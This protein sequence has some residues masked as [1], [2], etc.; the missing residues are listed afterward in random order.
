MATNRTLWSGEYLRLVVPQPATTVSG[1]PV[2]VGLVPGGIAGVCL[3]DPDDGD[4]ATVATIGGFSLFVNGV[5]DSVGQPI[6]YGDAADP[7]DR[8]SSD[9]TDRDFFGYALATGG[10]ELLPVLIGSSVLGVNQVQSVHVAD[11]SITAAKLDADAALRFATVT[12]T[13]PEIKLLNATPFELV[14]APGV[15]QM[16]EVQSVLLRQVV[17]AEVFDGGRT[18]DIGYDDV[19]TSALGANTVEPGDFHEVFT[20]MVYVAI[21]ED[22]LSGDPALFVNENLAITALAG[23]IGG[24]A[25]D[26]TVWNITVAYRVHDLS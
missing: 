16:L 19:T 13:A 18:L 10:N 2:F 5:V 1:S 20:D 23:E 25:T 6:Y 8:L 14:A 3:T 9:P 4:E 11:G 21:P 7:D 26:D 24:N 22:G 17:G 15:D 12:L